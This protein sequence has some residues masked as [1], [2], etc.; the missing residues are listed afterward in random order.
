MALKFCCGSGQRFQACNG[1]VWTD[2]QDSRKGRGSW[3]RQVGTWPDKLLGV[4]R[5]K[6]G[7]RRFPKV[8]AILLILYG[9]T[10]AIRLKTTLRG[11]PMKFRPDVGL[12]RRLP[13]QPS[14]RCDEGCGKGGC[15]R[16]AVDGWAGANAKPILRPIRLRSKAEG[17]RANAA[18]AWICP[19]PVGPSSAGCVRLPLRFPRQVGRYAGL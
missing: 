7:F 8:R 15:C 1:K 13:W 3:R 2:G 9:Q 19:Y 18:K 16:V 14:W 4:R 17:F 12:N 10:R 6:Y 5:G 11:A